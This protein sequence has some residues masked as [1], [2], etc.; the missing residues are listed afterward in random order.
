MK[1]HTHVG[2]M[3]LGNTLATPTKMNE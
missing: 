2:Y 1:L 3:S